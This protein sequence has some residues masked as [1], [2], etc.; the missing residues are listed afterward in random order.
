METLVMFGC[1]PAHSDDLVFKE[2]NRTPL[3]DRLASFIEAN[4]IRDA[5]VIRFL[6]DVSHGLGAQ[7]MW[8]AEMRKLDYA[9]ASW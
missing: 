8:S 5:R 3:E 2:K 6:E 4:H 9:A 7:K 1:A